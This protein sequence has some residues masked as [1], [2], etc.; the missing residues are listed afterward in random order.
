V[1]VTNIHSID[2]IVSDIERVSAKQHILPSE[3]TLGQYSKNGGLYDGRSLRIW[4][5]FASIVK[6]MAGI[7]SVAQLAGTKYMQ[8]RAKYVKKLENIVGDKAY[9]KQAMYDGF[10]KA[11]LEHGSFTISKNPPKM[12]LK[13]AAKRKKKRANAVLISD[14]HLGLNI[15]ADEVITNE[16]NWGV[17]AKRLGKLTEQVAL[18]KL[19]HRAECDEL[20]VCLNGDLGQGIIHLNDSGTELITY[21]VVGIV[22]YLT[23]M[24]DYWRN[25]Y[26]T[27]RVHC[28]PDNH[29]RLTH[30]GNDR[31]TSQKFDS[32]ATMIHMMLQAAFRT[33]TD[34]Q[35]NIPK[36]AITSFHSLGH[37][38]GMTHGDGHI[39]SGNVGHS[40]NVKGIANQV[41]RLNAAV[42]DPYDAI[43]LGHVHV[44]LFMH[45]NET[46]TY[47]VVNGTGSGVDPYAET[48]GYFRTMPCQTMW[49][50]TEQYPVGDFRIVD[51]TDAG[52][53]DTY[54]RFIKPYGHELSV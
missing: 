41:M 2:Q 18:Y 39:A 15:S 51:L 27:I 40:V 1:K 17:A 16:Y 42:D 4:G 32:F 53:D 20:N 19:D 8:T 44:P 9:I 49:E 30:K 13:N 34:V 52:K 23:Q 5:G 26:K 31:A 24:I 29:M 36:S 45:L 38:F 6:S 46:G 10:Q 50:I 43:L 3:I 35:F 47:L 28:T 25:Y 7:D 54:A 37:H 21:Q 33:C 12:V 11:L 14:I 48:L 22:S